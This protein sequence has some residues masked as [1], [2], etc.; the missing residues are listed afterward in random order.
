MTE[1]AK[2]YQRKSKSPADIGVHLLSN[3]HDGETKAIKIGATGHWNAKLF[4]L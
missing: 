2:C 1:R 3:E 4:N